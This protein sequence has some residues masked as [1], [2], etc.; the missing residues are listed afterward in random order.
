M[1]HKAVLLHSAFFEKL[2]LDYQWLTKA[3]PPPVDVQLPV[4]NPFDQLEEAD[5]MLEADIS[6][7][8]VSTSLRS[9]RSNPLTANIKDLR[10]QQ[11]QSRSWFEDGSE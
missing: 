3:N 4:V 10:R 6:R 2:F 8:M 1:S 5:S 11:T 9:S 7:I